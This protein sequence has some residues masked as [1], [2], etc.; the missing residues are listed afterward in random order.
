MHNVTLKPCFAPDA[1][2]HALVCSEAPRNNDPLGRGEFGRRVTNRRRC[3][4]QDMEVDRFDAPRPEGGCTDRAT[5]AGTTHGGS[6]KTAL[7]GHVREILL[8]MR[9]ESLSRRI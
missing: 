2:L 6:A 1:R 8:L 3:R 4:Y 7:Q 9:L 5:A